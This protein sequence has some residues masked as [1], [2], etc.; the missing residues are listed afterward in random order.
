MAATRNLQHYKREDF[1]C[2][3]P[4]QKPESKEASQANVLLLL[5]S[6]DATQVATPQY[7]TIGIQISPQQIVKTDAPRHQ[8][9]AY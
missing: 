2:K 1:V 5:P 3:A 9:A 8:L 6:E 4:T 7:E